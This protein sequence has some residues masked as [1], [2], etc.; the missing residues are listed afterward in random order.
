[1]MSRQLLINQ[2][3]IWRM[4]PSSSARFVQHLASP[5]IKY[6]AVFGNLIALLGLQ[7]IYCPRVTRSAYSGNKWASGR[8]AKL[9]SDVK[10]LNT[11]RP[12]QNGRFFPEDIFEYILLNYN[13]RISIKISLKFVSYGSINNIPALVQVMAWRRKGDKPLYDTNIA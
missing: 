4:R 12:K 13:V 6:L 5:C 1:M 8:V 11:L 10:S 9:L 7:E 2:N 3:L